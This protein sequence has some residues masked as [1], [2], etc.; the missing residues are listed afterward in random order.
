MRVDSSTLVPWIGE[1]LLAARQ[2]TGAIPTMDFLSDWKEHLPEPWANE[3]S[4]D[5]I[6]GSFMQPS[7]S[8]IQYRQETKTFDT[9]PT[10]LPSG[11]STNRKWHEKFKQTRK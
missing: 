8:T 2:N 4:L 1:M 7:S 3:T 10:N 6:Q 5:A 9:A 11:K